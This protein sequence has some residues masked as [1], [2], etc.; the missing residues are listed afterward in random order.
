MILPAITRF[1][2]ILVAVSSILQ[3]GTDLDIQ[4]FQKQEGGLDGLGVQP[5]VRSSTNS[6]SL[7]CVDLSIVGRPKALEP[8]D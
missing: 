5:L 4:S 1:L 8:P 7:A 3:E 2:R 6:S